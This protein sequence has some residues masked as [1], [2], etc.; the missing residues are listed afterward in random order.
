M[1]VASPQ[2]PPVTHERLRQSAQTLQ[3]NISL[4][5]RLARKRQ[6]QSLSH[7]MRQ[8]RRV[9]EGRYQCWR[10]R[11]FSDSRKIAAETLQ[12]Q[13]QRRVGL[14]GKGIRQHG[15]EETA[16]QLNGG[17]RRQ[18]IRLTKMAQPSKGRQWTSIKKNIGCV[19][20]SGV[21]PCPL[22][23]HK[24]TVSLQVYARHD[25]I[26]FETYIASLLYAKCLCVALPWMCQPLI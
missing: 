13:Q 14:I 18:G 1:A 12:Y 16:R 23:W 15:G 25:L 7:S 20:A 9:P 21:V 4:T 8:F 22:V 3:S 11:D 10:R 2:T 5:T 19:A 6:Q 26:H 17:S 24:P